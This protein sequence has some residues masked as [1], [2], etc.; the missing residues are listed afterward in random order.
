MV[1]YRQIQLRVDTPSVLNMSKSDFRE[2][3]IDGAF[4]RS[5]YGMP[6]GSLKFDKTIGDGNCFY[7]GVA[8]ATVGIQAKSVVMTIKNMLADFL[9]FHGN[10]KLISP[11]PGSTENMNYFQYYELLY[12]DERNERH[13]DNISSISDVNLRRRGNEVWSTY[14]RDPKALY[15]FH[16]EYIRQDGSYANDFDVGVLVH[17][18]YLMGMKI[19]INIY[20]MVLSP[21]KQYTVDLPAYDNVE[22][23]CLH[24]RMFN[25]T[26]NHFELNQHYIHSR[27]YH[28]RITEQEKEE[29]SREFKEK[30]TFMENKLQ[31]MLG[32]APW[33]PR[34]SQANNSYSP[35][36]Q[37]PLSRYSK[38][39]MDAKKMLAERAEQLKAMEHYDPNQ[40]VSQNTSVV[41][42]APISSFNR[43]V[44]SSIAQNNFID[45][46]AARN[47]PVIQNTPVVLTNS[48]PS[49]PLLTGSNNRRAR[50]AQTS[51]QQ[52]I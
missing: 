40:R 30:Q 3:M 31:R 15:D 29:R 48:S 39:Q 33:N 18:Y 2:V 16:C 13:H 21:G 9:V 10:K 47:V 38:E 28:R 23:A 22:P 34:Q 35:A 19:S 26:N 45:Q 12:L 43:H 44:S 6:D 25:V 8:M 41:Q 5:L 7:N 42:N 14:P 32:Y 24:I 27:E 52:K 20:Y 50:L 17:L 49:D 37:G 46:D 1:D 36:V 11:L 51:A 4:V